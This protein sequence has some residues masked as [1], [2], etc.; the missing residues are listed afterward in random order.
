MD[1]KEAHF[2]MEEL[3]RMTTQHRGVF[4]KE[5]IC[6]NGMAI[7]ALEKIQMIRTIPVLPKEYREYQTSNLDD[8]Y[9]KGWEDALDYAYKNM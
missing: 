8:A 3:Q 7:R 2:Y 6:A 1:Y 4:S 9:E 5:F